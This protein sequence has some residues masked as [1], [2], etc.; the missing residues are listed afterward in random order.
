[1]P[2]REALRRCRDLRVMRPSMDKYRRASREILA[3]YKSVTALVEPLSLDEAFLDVTGV[4][5]FAGSATRI[6][7]DIKNRVRNDVGITV[8]AGVAPNKFL[9][10]IASDWEKPDGLTVV[11]PADVDAFVAALPIERIF[12]VGAVTAG[13]L[14]RAGF[15]TCQDVR[16]RSRQDLKQMFGALGD[17]L[18]ELSRGIDHRRVNP[19]ALRKSL[20]VEETFG[21]DLKSLAQCTVELDRLIADLA[22]QAQ[23]LKSGD[24]IDAVVVKIRFDD[25]RK[26]TVERRATQIHAAQLKEMLAIG[27]ARHARPVRLLGVGVRVVHDDYRLQMA[28]FDAAAPALQSEN[29]NPT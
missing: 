13:R 22:W 21:T 7:R 26:T 2:T 8:S 27:V 5:L 3:I 20:S 9:A 1:M 23:R 10:K 11:L 28:L 12:G 4:R 24:R 29:G 25:F 16:A 19:D 15:H 18:Y 17:R 14:K 6:A